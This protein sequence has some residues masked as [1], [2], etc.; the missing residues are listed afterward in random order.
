MQYV[1]ALQPQVARDDVTHDKGL[2][3]AHVQIA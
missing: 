2:R 1:V 3:V